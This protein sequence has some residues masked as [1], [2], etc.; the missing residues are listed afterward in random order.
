MF[1]EFIVPI[2]ITISDRRTPG[3]CHHKTEAGVESG[4]DIAKKIPTSLLQILDLTAP[5][6]VLMSMEESSSNILR[7]INILMVLSY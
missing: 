3:I 2:V 5:A 4:S 6:F 7:T 1:V